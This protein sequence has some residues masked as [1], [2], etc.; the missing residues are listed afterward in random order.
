MSFKE[1]ICSRTKL[2]LKILK[3][4]LATL[5]SFNYCGPASGLRHGW[6]RYE[7]SDTTP[8][9]HWNTM[10]CRI[11]LV[12]D[13]RRLNVTKISFYGL[14]DAYFLQDISAIVNTCIK[15][16]YCDEFLNSFSCCNTN[17]SEYFFR[18]CKILSHKQPRV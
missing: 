3:I 10:S 5:R 1:L 16:S 18:P 6:W 9:I 14:I 15:R 11:N 13:P 12:K 4:F 17:S 7:T 2:L 8:R